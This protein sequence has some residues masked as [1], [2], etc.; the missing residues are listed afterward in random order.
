M[1]EQGEEP[2]HV[3]QVAAYTT[4]QPN[5]W[6]TLEEQKVAKRAVETLQNRQEVS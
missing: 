6:K 3:L 2:I 5:W 4:K 1:A